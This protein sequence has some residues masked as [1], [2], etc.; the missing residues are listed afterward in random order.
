MASGTIV[1][2]NFNVLSVIGLWR[3]LLT[4][5]STLRLY[6][7]NHTPSPADTWAAYTEATFTGYS[8]ASLTGLYPTPT[9]VVNGEYEM[10]LPSQSFNCSSGSGQTAYGAA[11]L[12]ASGNL[13]FV[14]P[15]TTPIVFTAGLTY[16]VA[17]TLQEWAASVIP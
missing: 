1:S 7:N 12:D 14:C 5:G 9:V 4:A 8:Y 6:V 3:S 10:V 17:V 2:T 15:F 13:W 16:G 11:I